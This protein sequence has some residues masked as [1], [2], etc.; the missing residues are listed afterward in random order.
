M[1]ANGTQQTQSWDISP[2]DIR[3]KKLKT[4]LNLVVLDLTHFIRNTILVVVTLF[5]PE[6]D[7]SR[8]LHLIPALWRFGIPLAG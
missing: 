3:T 2:L 8:S 1:G 6:Y 7:S 4:V 5:Y